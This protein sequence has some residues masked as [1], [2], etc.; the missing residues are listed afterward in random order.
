MQ[1]EK[2]DRPPRPPAAEAI[3]LCNIVWKLIE[4]CWQ[5]QPEARPVVEDVSAI[6]NT[7]R[8]H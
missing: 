6:L 4:H 1:I 8:S 7:V 3:G 5:A 2:G